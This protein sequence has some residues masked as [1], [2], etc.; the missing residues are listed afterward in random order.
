M[1]TPAPPGTS[2]ISP[3]RASE[4]MTIGGAYCQH[5]AQTMIAVAFMTLQHMF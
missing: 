4:T 1:Q 3:Q 5:L 2:E